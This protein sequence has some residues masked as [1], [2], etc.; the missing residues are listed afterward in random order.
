MIYFSKKVPSGDLDKVNDTFQISKVGLARQHYSAH[1]R[2]RLMHGK[3]GQRSAEENCVKAQRPP[4]M[5]PHLVFES[6]KKKG[7]EALRGVPRK[8]GS[9]RRI[10]GFSGESCGLL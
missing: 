5:V 9:Q 8:K 4:R 3:A 6:Q 1:E 7:A 10:I 2:A